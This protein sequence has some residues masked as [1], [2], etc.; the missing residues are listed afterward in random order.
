MSWEEMEVPISDIQW[1][2]EDYD[3]EIDSPDG[4][5]PVSRFVDKGMW[6]EYVVDDGVGNSVRVNENHLFLCERGWVLTKE[7]L[8]TDRILKDDGSYHSVQVTKTGNR[9]PIV[10]LAIDHENHRY[11]ANGFTSHNTNVGK[12]A[13]MIFLASEFLRMGKN[14]L[15]ITLEMD[16]DSVYERVDA[17]LL[18]VPTDKLDQLSKEDFMSRVGKLKEKTH[19]KFKCK[20][21]PT[22]SAHVGHFRYLL[23]E[24]KQKS[25]FE[26]DFVFVDYINICASSRYK[27]GSGSINSYSYVKAIAEE[28]RGL[29]VEFDL[30]I[31]TATQVN[32]DGMNN[33]NPDMTST[34]ESFGL[35][36]T[37]DWF[38]ALT[39]DE[40][41]RENGQQQVH[42]LKTRWG[43]KQRV[44]S[45]MVGI[46][47]DLMRYYD[48]GSTREAQ[49]SMGKNKPNVS[50]DKEATS[51]SNKEEVKPT[52]PKRNKSV[53]GIDWD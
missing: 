4:Y 13:L 29:A 2:M 12:S 43:N 21:F 53:E 46:D 52:T 31:M 24:L 26:P 9:I 10:D 6:N 32:R 40:V 23:K 39:A 50:N 30:P 11:Y 19:G 17:N 48:V 33:Q 15:Y 14:V 27:A 42:L 41:M 7:M 22:S 44:G 47:W 35:P 28:I 34:S 36:A 18:G 8:A 37:L 51:S 45:Q 20:E 3:V 1:L 5:V 25:N 16:E 49:S 38:I